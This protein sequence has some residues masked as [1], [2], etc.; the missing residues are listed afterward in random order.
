MWVIEMRPIT[1]FL[2]ILVAL[3][4]LDQ[5]LAAGQREDINAAFKFTDRGDYVS[6]LKILVPL[7]DEGVS[8]AQALLGALYLEGKG[9][10]RDYAKAVAWYRKS[11]E[12]GFAGAQFELGAM[13]DK[14]MGVS[15]DTREAA[16]WFSKAA[17]A[18]VGKAQYNLA[19]MYANGEGV[20]QDWVL[21][22][23]WFSLAAVN[24]VANGSKGR[25]AA[26]K[27][28]SPRDVARAQRMAR[29]WIEKH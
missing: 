17:E 15:R 11:A 12:Q 21:A 16:K 28:L 4:L 3:A 5:P 18:G 29:E 14:G 23:M 1:S 19:S 25:D 27:N 13:Y 10:K 22:H 26:E 7:A 24:G 9:V 8:I 6:A 2:A 20:A